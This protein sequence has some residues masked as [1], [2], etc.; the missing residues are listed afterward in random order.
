MKPR[1]LFVGLI[2]AALLAACGSTPRSNYYMLSSD[3][4]GVP[5]G[6]GPAIGVGPVTVPDYLRNREMVLNRDNHRLRMESYERWAEPL[7]AG[8]LRVTALNLAR[9]LDT[10]QVQAFPWTRAAT[11]DFSI[12]ISVVELSMQGDQARLVASWSIAQTGPDK[13]LTQ[14]ISQLTESRRSDDAAGVAA[15]YSALLLQLSREIAAA[16]PRP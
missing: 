11:P 10:Q 2:V 15:A 5:G 14:Q 13:V 3:A 6:G 16:V 8:I 4:P 9:L 12:R 7:D 1:N